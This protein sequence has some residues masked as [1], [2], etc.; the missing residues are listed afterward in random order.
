MEKT[1][2]V[3]K[4]K[5]IVGS[6]LCISSHDGERVYLEIAK[7]LR[8][9]FCIK[10]S[11]EDIEDLTSAFLNSAVG[12]LYN[13]EFEYETISENLLMNSE[14]TKTSTNVAHRPALILLISSEYFSTLG[15][16]LPENGP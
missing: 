10:L 1:K 13:H 6:N 16:I 8:K 12:R 2:K 9:G 4:I 14:I 15:W 5:D 3:I 11:F 7:A